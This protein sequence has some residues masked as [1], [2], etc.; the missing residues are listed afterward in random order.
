LGKLTRYRPLPDQPYDP[1]VTDLSKPFNV[2]AATGPQAIQT[3]AAGNP[4]GPAGFGLAGNAKDQWR[5]RTISNTFPISLLAGVAIRVL[6]ANPRRTGLL[7][8]NKDAAATL[9]FAFGNIADINGL[10]IAAGGGILYDFSTPATELYLF[11]AAANIQATVQ[12]MSRV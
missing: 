4:I 9:F 1:R 10:Q 12:E 3:D 2:P 5:N 6:P 8:Q 11:C 7:I